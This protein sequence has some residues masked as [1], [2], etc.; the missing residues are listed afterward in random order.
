MFKIAT[1]IG[2][3]ADCGA[4]IYP[5]RQDPETRGARFAG[6][7]VQLRCVSPGEAYAVPSAEG[8]K[9]TVLAIMTPAPRYGEGDIAAAAVVAALED[10]GRAGASSAAVFAA[11]V[12]RAD[13]LIGSVIPAI[14]AY[15]EEKDFDAVVISDD[16][17][18]EAL[19]SRVPD[20]LTA[21]L[22]VPKFPEPRQLYAE[23]SG[24]VK[25]SEK[26]RRMRS[27]HPAAAREDAFI[28]PSFEEPDVMESALPDFTKAVGQAAALSGELDH[29]IGQI[30]ESF[31]EML[32]RLIDEA[33]ISD[34]ECYKRANVDR[35]LFSKIRSNRLYKPSKQT[36]VAFA[37]ALRLD[38]V[39]TKDLLMKAGFALSRSSIFDIIVEYFISRGVWDVFTINE[40]LFAYDQ[41]VL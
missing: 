38:V 16:A 3:A 20:D 25:K 4:F 13:V 9:K 8:E 5:V 39:K 2:A 17:V 35:K 41:P 36:A 1:D 19:R 28:S 24:T 29:L 18:R 7:Q 34:A 14:K 31:S 32:L 12:I 6:R 27:E 30:D 40:A 33:G 26:P 11:G 22:T 23:A 15:L 21:L 37:I 10:S